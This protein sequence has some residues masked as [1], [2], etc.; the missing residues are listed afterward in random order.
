METKEVMLLTVIITT[1]DPGDGK[2]TQVASRTIESLLQHLQYDNLQWII[3]D[4]GSAEGHVETLAKL[5]EGKPYHISVVPRLGV[6]ASKNAALRKAFETSP[7]VLLLEDDWV[8]IQPLSLTPYVNLLIEHEDL[9][10]VR[11]G[12][13]G[14]NLEAAF[15]G[16]AHLSYW[17]L[18]RG[19]GVYVY[20]G[21]V[22]LRH[23]R[24]Y[25]VVGF[26]QEGISPGEED[27]EMCKRFNGTE[28]ALAI[29]W[30][31]NIPCTF[32]AG[33]FRHDDHGVSLNNITPG[34]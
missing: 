20:S 4:D 23:K 24:F 1:Y 18:K 19:S 33:L 5:L 29:V 27:L 28:N 32:N 26:H 3:A 13:L 12:Y 6:G 30:P 9:G 10:M 16:D 15:E 31:A 7:M 8:L 2:R 25:D 11:F 34:S 14:G 22:S 21:Q 17:R